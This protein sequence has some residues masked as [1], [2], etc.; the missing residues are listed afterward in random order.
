MQIA[1][2]GSWSKEDQMASVP[3]KK[4]ARKAQKPPPKSATAKTATVNT[5][6][7]AKLKAAAEVVL[8]DLR[9]TPT[10]AVRLYYTQIALRRGL[11]FDL[12]VPNPAT[13][14]ALEEA[15]RGAGKVYRGSSSE[16]IEAMLH[17]AE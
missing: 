1:Y 9:L 17:D 3:A 5:R 11:P 16:I 8:R 15:E 6:I 13:V 2:I 12:A 14:A 10:D 7:D 4:S